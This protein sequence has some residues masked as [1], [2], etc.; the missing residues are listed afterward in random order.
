MC[1]L[2]L[3]LFC[4][5][6][7]M[8]TWSFYLYVCCVILTQTGIILCMFTVFVSFVGVVSCY[9]YTLYFHVVTY[10]HMFLSVEL[11]VHIGILLILFV[12]LD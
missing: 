8:R 12:S 5:V 11:I 4:P 9:I 3:L 6:M 7:K 2:G 1:S 10:W